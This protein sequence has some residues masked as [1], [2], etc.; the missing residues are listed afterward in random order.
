MC[1]EKQFTRPL[2]RCVRGPATSST[3]AE[4][5]TYT[6]R[7]GGGCGRGYAQ[8]GATMHCSRVHAI[9]TQVRWVDTLN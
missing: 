6:R 8:G 2:P 3:G 9:V 1:S 5:P 7:G 4:L